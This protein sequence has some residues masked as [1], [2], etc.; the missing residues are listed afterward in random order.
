VRFGEDLLAGR[1]NEVFTTLGRRWQASLGDPTVTGWVTIGTLVLV[2][3]VYAILAATG[4]VGPG[5]RMR[6]R[7]QPTVAAAAGLAVL[8][9]LGVVANDS[10]FTVPATMLIV[11]VPA[12]VL[13]KMSQQPQ[14]ARVPAAAGD[15][16][17]Q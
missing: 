6:E 9:T 17:R 14:G 15:G 2:A 13:R 3:S 5:A 4:H 1:W 11:V 7:H 8:G 12:L 16:G 10:S